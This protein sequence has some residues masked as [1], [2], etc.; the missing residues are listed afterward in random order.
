M[1]N[2]PSVVKFVM[3]LVLLAPIAP[4]D[5]T[6]TTWEHIFGSKTLVF[7]THSICGNNLRTISKL[8]IRLVSLQLGHVALK[9]YFCYFENE[10]F[11]R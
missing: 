8:S 9:V 1:K 6:I 10:H 11:R 3:S 4:L 2:D 7:M 5:N